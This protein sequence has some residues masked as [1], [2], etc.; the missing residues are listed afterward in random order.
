MGVIWVDAP[1]D[2]EDQR[3][4]EIWFSALYPRDGGGGERHTMSAAR[5]VE[6]VYEWVE[7]GY[8]SIEAY[9]STATEFVGPDPFYN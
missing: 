1:R 2:Y 3:I 4:T 8:G 9:R 6:H 5:A 7:D